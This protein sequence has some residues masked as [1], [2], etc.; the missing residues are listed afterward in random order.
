ME[1]EL[2][3]SIPALRQVGSTLLG[4]APANLSLKAGDM[5]NNTLIVLA[6]PCLKAG[7][8]SISMSSTPWGRFLSMEIV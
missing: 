2:I 7:V 4:I 6:N 1:L 5:E 8:Q 3:S